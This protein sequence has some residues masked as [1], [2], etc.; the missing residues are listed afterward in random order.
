MGCKKFKMNPKMD[1]SSMMAH[2][3][4]KYTVFLQRDE[5]ILDLPRQV[6]MIPR[7]EAVRIYYESIEQEIIDRH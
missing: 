5:I 2:F 1:K 6:C 3:H 7:S 4:K